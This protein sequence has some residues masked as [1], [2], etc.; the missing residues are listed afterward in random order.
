M[1]FNVITAFIALVHAN[2]FQ[3]FNLPCTCQKKL[4]TPPPPPKQKKG[5]QEES[6]D[7]KRI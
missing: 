1:I 7:T 5:K 6:W 3:I 2:Y 4:P